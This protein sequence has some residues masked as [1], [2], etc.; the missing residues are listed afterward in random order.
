MKPSGEIIKYILNQFTHVE[1]IILHGSR[2]AGF[3][4][5]HSDWDYIVLVS[6]FQKQ[7]I[8][9]HEIDGFHFEFKV[10]VLPVKKQ[11][12]FLR[13]NTKLQFAEVV[14]DKNN[15][16]RKLI[17]DAKSF[18]SEGIPKK[19]LDSKIKKHRKMNRAHALNN[20]RDNL[21]FPAMFQ[22]K[23][24]G[25][26]PQIINDWYWFVKKDYPKNL[27][28]SIPQIEKEDPF[29]YKLLLPFF[30]ESHTREEKISSTEKIIE[31]VY[32]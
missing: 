20:L 26:Y 17:E 18:Y 28:I 13:F 21:D 30:K 7:D 6:K 9:R 3:A 27:Y 23:I 1:A 12:I 19:F 32:K 8:F 4:R 31:Y 14:F 29:F 11:D 22:K 10:E 5:E 16:G 2:V 15:F 24:Q 25:I